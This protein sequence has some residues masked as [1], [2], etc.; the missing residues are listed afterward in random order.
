MNDQKA[1]SGDLLSRLVKD[2]EAMKKKGHEA[3]ILCGAETFKFLDRC[4]G[5]KGSFMGFRYREMKNHVPFYVHLRKSEKE[6]L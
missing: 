5:E 3:E 1:E 4:T 2:I 6:N